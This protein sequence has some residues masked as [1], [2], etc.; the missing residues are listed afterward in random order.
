M[1]LNV[2]VVDYGMGNLHSVAKAIALQGARVNVTDSRLKLKDS[3][4]LV[5]PG[6]GAFGAAMT[7]LAKKK[8]DDFI[9]QWIEA[10]R[11]YLGICLGFQLLFDRS[12]E[13]RKVEGLGVF[14]GP[15]VKFRQSDF[16][17]KGFQ[18]PHMGWN[19]AER[20][21]KGA[22]GYFKGLRAKDFFYFVH[23]YYPVPKDKSVIYSETSY[24]KNFCSS[25]AKGNLFASQFHPEKSGRIGLR[26]LKNIL[27]KAA[28]C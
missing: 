7:T 3:D 21:S 25:V 1:K 17:K 2:G 19:S 16:K 6:V 9:R 8:L 18:I 20:K 28:Q 4:L 10:G 22:S 14:E 15:V 26:L 27:E 5:L 13:S 11:P 12:E 23:S 24:G